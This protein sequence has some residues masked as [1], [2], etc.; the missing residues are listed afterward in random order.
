[1]LLVQIIKKRDPFSGYIEIFRGCGYLA[2]SANFTSAGVSTD[3][4]ANVATIG[5]SAVTAIGISA[6]STAVVR[7]IVESTVSAYSTCSACSAYSAIPSILV[8]KRLRCPDSCQGSYGQNC[9]YGR[10]HKYSCFVIQVSSR[11]FQNNMAY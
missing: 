4:V 8:C 7:V 10:S 2:A 11:T 6:I 3:M 9:R 1:M 5:T